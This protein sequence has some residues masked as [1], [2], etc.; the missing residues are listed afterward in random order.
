MI[1]TAQWKGRAAS[2]YRPLQQVSLT[3]LSVAVASAMAS[4]LPH[5][6]PPYGAPPHPTY[7]QV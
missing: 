7:I 2:D 3:L 4:F 1:E 5:A 6:P